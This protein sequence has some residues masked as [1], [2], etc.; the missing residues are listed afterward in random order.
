MK[1]VKEKF[2]SMK[3][4]IYGDSFGSEEPVF[5]T[6][7]NNLNKIDPS[8]VTLLKEDFS[9][10]NFCESGSDYYFSFNNFV[11]NYKKYSLNIFLKTSPHRLSLPYKNKYIHN[12]NI[13]SS[14]AKL[15]NETDKTKIKMLKASIDYF[16]YL[17][18]EKKD[19]VISDL[20][21]EKILSLDPNCL[22]VDSFGNNGLFNVT[23]MENKIWKFN[24]TYTKKDEFLDLRYCHMTQENNK[25]MYNKIKECIEKQIKF[26]FNL[27]DFVIPSMNTKD[28]YLVKR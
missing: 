14:I 24:P 7:H 8:W 2:L 10:D 3:I 22:I 27:S 25:I 19:L 9:V 28:L 18:D 20:F 16:K 13:N 4:A 21:T 23:L 15:E 1:N 26:N 17:Q 6:Y 12:H 11:E 5:Q